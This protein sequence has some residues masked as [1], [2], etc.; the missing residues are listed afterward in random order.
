MH[1]AHAFLA[2]LHQVPLALHEGVILFGLAL[3]RAGGFGDVGFGVGFK[4]LAD[5]ENIAII[6]AGEDSDDHEE[7]HKC[8]HGR[9]IAYVFIRI[10]LEML[11]L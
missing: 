10:N 1:V 6:E 3:P 8:F 9:S 2:L 7:C 11:K 4:R 5:H